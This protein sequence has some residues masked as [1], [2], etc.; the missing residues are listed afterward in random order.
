MI[1][2]ENEETAASA[3]GEVH[4]SSVATAVTPTRTRRNGDATV[5]YDS[6]AGFGKRSKPLLPSAMLAFSPRRRPSTTRSFSQ[7][8]LQ[9]TF[10]RSSYS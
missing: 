5:S 7:V 4:D 1:G 6:L 2:L 10:R 8:T 9:C 3:N